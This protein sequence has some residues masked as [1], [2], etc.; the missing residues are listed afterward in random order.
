MARCPR[1]SQGGSFTTSMW[2]RFADWIDGELRAREIQSVIGGT[3]TNS[4]GGVSLNLQ[5]NRRIA[6]NVR[7]P[8][9]IVSRVNESEQI[10]IILWP[11]TI[12][13]IMPSNIFTWTTVD[14][15]S[16]WY[17]KALV[18]T[19]GSAVTGATIKID[20]TAATAQTATLNS[21]PTVVQVLIGVYGLGTAYNIKNGNV[22]MSGNQTFSRGFWVIS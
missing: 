1:L 17:A 2:D 21:L 7:K 16:T 4:P 20:N 11:G 19:D 9:D 12:N 8:F 5:G 18:T 6:D 22:T 10:E 3:F 13:G 14:A 15:T